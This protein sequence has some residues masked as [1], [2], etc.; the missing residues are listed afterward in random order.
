M[1]LLS[2][3]QT[4]KTMLFAAIVIFPV[5]GYL[6]LV[7]WRRFQRAE[8][9]ARKFGTSSRPLSTMTLKEAYAIIDKLQTLEFPTAFNKARAYAL[10]KVCAAR[11]NRSG[12]RVFTFLHRLEAFQQSRKFSW[13]QDKVLKRWRLNVRWTQTCYW[14]SFRRMM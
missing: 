1:I 11:R 7:Q 3:I 9:I 8:Q 2:K 14:W 4:K 10:L 6:C 13:L 12:S 5:L